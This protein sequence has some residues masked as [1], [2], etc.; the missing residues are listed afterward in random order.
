MTSRNKSDALFERSKV[1]MRR[2]YDKESLRAIKQVLRNAIK[3][4]DRGLVCDPGDMG[5][6][7]VELECLVGELALQGYEDADEAVLWFREAGPAP[8]L[9]ALLEENVWQE[10]AT[11]A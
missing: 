8:E 3:A 2:S 5:L 6:I 9:T 11:K 7:A 10:A 1:I 4:V